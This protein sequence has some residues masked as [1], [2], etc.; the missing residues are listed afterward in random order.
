MPRGAE[1]NGPDAARRARQAAKAKEVFEKEAKERM[2][3]GGKN[4]GV[5]TLPPLEVCQGARRKAE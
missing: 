2:I 4:K 5:V 1:R 3:E